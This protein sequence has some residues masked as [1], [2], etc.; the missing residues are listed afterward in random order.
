MIVILIGVSGS[1][2]TTIGKQ[3]ADSLE[4]KF[5]DGD[6]F[7]PPE[8][9]EKMQA[10]IPLEDAD[11]IP[12]LQVIRDAIAQWLRENKNVVLTCSALK[13]SYRQMLSI[14]SKDVKF[15]YLKGSFE[16]IEKRL[17]DRKHHFMSERLLE[18][19]FDALEEPSNAIAVDISSPTE[20][21]VENIRRSVK[22]LLEE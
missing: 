1:G 8:N 12:W 4:W 10:G 20:E 7:H 3:L 15:I 18:S 6:D 9:I 11:R 19:Q 2:K 14:N 17:Q 16:L 21:I 13:E 5:Y 22:G